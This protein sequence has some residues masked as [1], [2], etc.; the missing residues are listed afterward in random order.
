MDYEFHREPTRGIIAKFSMGHEAL[1][2]WLTEEIRGDLSALSEVENI[3][4]QLRGSEREWHKEGH[5]YSLLIRG[6]EVIVQAN[7]L[8]FPEDEVAEGL[9][10]YDA[11]S[12]SICGIED[13]LQVLRAYRLFSLEEG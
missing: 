12:H 2:Y 9:S 10:Y 13:F 5:E 1:G 7:S 4:Q 6:G 8:T 3:A 11:E